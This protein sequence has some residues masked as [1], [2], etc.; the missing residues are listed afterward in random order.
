VAKSGVWRG[1]GSGGEVG[2]T[3]L[4][5]GLYEFCR[6]NVGNGRDMGNVGMDNIRGMYKNAKY[7]F[8]MHACKP[9]THK[10]H[11]HVF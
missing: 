10:G 2:G 9:K 7:E 8:C 11:L 6:G 5:C 4:F 3:W 1:V